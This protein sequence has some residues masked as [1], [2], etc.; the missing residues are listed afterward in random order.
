MLD[1]RVF[2]QTVARLILARE[3]VK[4]L[5]TW[6]KNTKPVVVTE[7]DLRGLERAES[8]TGGILKYELVDR[9]ISPAE[10][11]KRVGPV[12]FLVMSVRVEQAIELFGTDALKGL[13][14]EAPPRV[15]LLTQPAPQA[16]K[17]KILVP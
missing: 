9:S 13:I 15:Q 2:G 6:D 17:V 14:F 7:M 4:K 5:T 10:L 11:F 3:A 16:H 12:A 1:N 8:P